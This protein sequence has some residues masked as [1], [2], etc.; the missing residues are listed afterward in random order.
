[1]LI[2]NLQGFSEFH[3]LYCPENCK[4]PVF[5]KPSLIG[6]VTTLINQCH[7]CSVILHSMIV[8]TVKT[9]NLQVF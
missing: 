8:T 1:M 4:E 3:I 9:D 7:Y 5:T 2:F 6:K